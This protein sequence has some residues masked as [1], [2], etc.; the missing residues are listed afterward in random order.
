L[1][2]K[3]PV[4]VNCWLVPT[5]LLGF[6]GV[7]AMDTSVD[8]VT[9][10]LIHP[11]TSPIVTL[12]VASPACLPYIVICPGAFNAA[13]VMPA[14]LI[15]AMVVSVESHAAEVVKSCVVLFE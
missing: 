2:E 6:V 13:A 5:A 9:L 8:G 1:S 14:E 3:V 12:M 4:A 11:D 7:T 15:V 10:R